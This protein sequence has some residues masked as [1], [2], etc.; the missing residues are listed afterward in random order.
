MGG[1][2]ANA[3]GVASADTVA[4]WNGGSWSGLGSVSPF[5]SGFGRVFNLAPHGGWLYVGGWFQNAAGKAAA[6]NVARWGLPGS[7]KPDGRI[8]L[9]T[10]GPLAGNNVY[11]TTGAGQTRTGSAARG[12]TITYGVSIQNDSTT[13]ADRFKVKATGAATSQYTVTYLSGVTDITSA[14]V[15]GTYLTPFLAP[16]GSYLITVRVKV[17][18]NAAVG[19]SVARLVTLTSVANPSKRDAVKLVG[20]RA[21]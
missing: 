21:G 20:R 2:F 1:A 12:A 13:S 16:G 6:D 5:P 17:R 11:N 7:R 18:S 8:R 10:S 19:S 9:G 4:R 15:A 14:V 3:G